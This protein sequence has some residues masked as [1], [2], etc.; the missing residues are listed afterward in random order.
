M[1]N[2]DKDNSSGTPIPAATDMSL[3]QDAEPG[4][5]GKAT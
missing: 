4:L 5:H 3:V 2:R 1:E